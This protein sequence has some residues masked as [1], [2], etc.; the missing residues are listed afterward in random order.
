MCAQAQNF[1][2]P[3]KVKLQGRFKRSFE[4]QLKKTLNFLTMSLPRMKI[5]FRVANRE[6]TVEQRMAHSPIVSTKESSHVQV[7]N[8]S[9]TDCVL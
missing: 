3:A 7:H 5:G 4:T 2:E 8:E 9:N 1:N 6:Q